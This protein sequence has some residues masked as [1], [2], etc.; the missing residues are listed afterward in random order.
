MRNGGFLIVE[1][2]LVEHAVRPVY[3]STACIIHA[4]DLVTGWM[5]CRHHQERV[6]VL[7]T[8]GLQ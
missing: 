2:Q 7:Y 3:V 5:S 1:S 8:A 6:R 4:V